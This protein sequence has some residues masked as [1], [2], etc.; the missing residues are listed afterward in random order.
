MK[1][2]KTII[3]ALVLVLTTSAV[4]A[5]SLH[6]TKASGTIT[7]T[8][9]TTNK[10]LGSMPATPNS[11][12]PVMNF[13]KSFVVVDGPSLQTYTSTCKLIGKLSIALNALVGNPTS[14]NG[15]FS[16]NTGGTV[17]NY[18]VIAMMIIF[19]VFIE[20]RS[21]LLLLKIVFLFEPLKN[22]TNL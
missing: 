16:V 13:T 2:L 20:Y 5:Q 21:Y 8:D 7:C 1:T 19:F 12:I 9:A 6:V 4:S 11:S 15:V 10:T 22:G 3:A 18:A 17:A 14:P